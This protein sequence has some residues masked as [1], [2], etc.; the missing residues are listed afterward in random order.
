VYVPFSISPELVDP[1]RRGDPAATERLIETIW[2][3]AVRLATAIVGDRSG[4][5]DAAQDACIALYRRIET[6]RTPEAFSTW[7]YRIVVRAASSIRRRGPIDTYAADADTFHV[8]VAGSIDV[9]RA[10]A[11]LPAG[12]RR[13]VILHYFEDL[14][15]AEIGAILRMPAPTIRFQLALARRRLRPLLADARNVDADARASEVPSHAI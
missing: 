9:W 4:G 8:D 10:L 3:D 1:A 12:L 5:E 2:A 14:S 15:S 13:V 6:L 11:S 7:F